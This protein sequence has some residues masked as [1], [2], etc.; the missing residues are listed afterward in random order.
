[1]LVIL[2]L[3]SYKPISHKKHIYFYIYRASNN[4]LDSQ[5]SNIFSNYWKE[6]FSSEKQQRF[7]SKHVRMSFLHKIIYFM[8]QIS[9]KQLHS[10]FYLFDA[11]YI[12]Q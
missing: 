7:G 8:D 10:E 9:R 11:A 1:M 4:F 3:V 5:Y 2:V 6:I 12:A